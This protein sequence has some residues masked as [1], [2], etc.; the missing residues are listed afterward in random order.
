MM[1]RITIR[2]KKN[3]FASD[4]T[5]LNIERFNNS[6]SHSIIITITAIL[7]ILERY[8]LRARAD[9]KKISVKQ[10]LNKIRCH[11]IGKKGI[12]NIVKITSINKTELLVVKNLLD[13]F[14]K[15]CISE[16]ILYFYYKTT[17]FNMCFKR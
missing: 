6:D 5:E 13:T 4:E 7:K 11:S 9:S 12:K 2:M 3:I 15:K 14:E 16:P 1:N 8:L 17:F 10:M